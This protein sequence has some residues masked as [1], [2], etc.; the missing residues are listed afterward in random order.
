[1]PAPAHCVSD[2]QQGTRAQRFC[3]LPL[4]CIATAMYCAG[5]DVTNRR[6]SGNAAITCNLG[7]M[8]VGQQRV[9]AIQ[10]R[11]PTPGVL[12]NSAIVGTPDE[13][14]TS[15]NAADEL[16][17]VFQPTCAAATADG[18]PFACSPG[19]AVSSALASSTTV[20][21]QGCCAAAPAPL[22][23]IRKM[24][25]PGPIPTN[26]DFIMYITVSLA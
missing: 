2:S 20:T 11:A 21:Q 22:L 7:N 16:N 15:D 24:G 1:M 26:T 8:P 14:F 6:Q 5:C 12:L 23:S 13:L 18:R 10:I 9:F 25:P 4:P 17:S 19:T 3:L